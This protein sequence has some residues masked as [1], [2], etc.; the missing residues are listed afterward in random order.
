MKRFGISPA[1]PQSKCILGLDP[2]HGCMALFAISSV[3]SSQFCMENQTFLPAHL[4]SL[5]RPGR[6]TGLLRQTST[7]P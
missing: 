4:G 3:S 1:V 5:P 6:F 7:V 2:T